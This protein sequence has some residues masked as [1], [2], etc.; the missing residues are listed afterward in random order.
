MKKLIIIAIIAAFLSPLVII[1]NALS[2]CAPQF[3]KVGEKSNRNIKGKS[4]TKATQ[5]DGNKAKAGK[6]KLRK[7]TA[8]ERIKSKGSVNE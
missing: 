5:I 1:E 7:G 8:N 2:E 4:A 3:R 6:V